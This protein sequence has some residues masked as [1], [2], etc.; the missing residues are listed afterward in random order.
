[1]SSRQTSG[2]TLARHYLEVHR[3]QAALDALAGVTGDDLDDA[4]Y[5][6]IRAEALL[7]LDRAAE[8]ADAAR[9]GLEHD[10]QDISL[11]DALALCELDGGDLAAAQQA[12]DSAL[13]I[14]PD[15]PV[16]LSHR[17]LAL[18][19]DK[20]Y[21]AAREAVEHAMSVDP[22]S[23]SVL[24]VQAQVAVLADDREAEHYIDEL[25][26][27]DPEDRIGHALRG[28]LAVKQK[29]FKQASKA[30]REAARLDPRDKEIAGVARNARVAA[31]PLLAPVRPM[32]R[33][34]RWRSYFLYLT[35]ITVLAAARLQTLRI[36]VICVWLVIVI[37]S[38]V[39][40]RILR[41]LE[42][43]KYGGF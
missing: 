17:A 12:L 33:F 3:P 8:G 30:F 36:V 16:L 39:G 43:R 21:D 15:H 18:A 10:P 4:E 1:M 5:W 19:L 41:R 32:W 42:E 28:N 24:R 25:L 38:W 37:L 34:G 14:L 11:L 6:T 40:P 35:L 31:H 7:E 2:L 22:E 23:R 26:A 27:A 9:R 13:A 20:R 29:R